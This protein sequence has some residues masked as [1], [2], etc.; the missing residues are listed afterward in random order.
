MHGLDSGRG[1]F[2]ALFALTVLGVVAFVAIKTIPPYV[3][4]Y[5][6]QDHIRQIAIQAAARTR[7]ITP[8]EIRNEVIAFAQEQG[9]PVTAENV[10]VTITTKVNIDLDYMVPVDLKVYTMMLHF[11]PSAE[12]RSL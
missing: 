12:D 10:K 8:D 4:N 2:K 11:T 1:T 9:L 6:L 7:P 3:G 5:E